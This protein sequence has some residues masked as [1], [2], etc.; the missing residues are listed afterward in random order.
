MW[1]FKKDY[2]DYQNWKALKP[3]DG[4]LLVVEVWLVE[5]SND[6]GSLTLVATNH[7]CFSQQWFRKTKSLHDRSFSLWIGKENMVLAKVVG[8]LHLWFDEYRIVFMYQSLKGNLVVIAYLL[9]GGFTMTFNKRNAIHKNNNIFHYEW[10][11]YNLYFKLKMYS[12][13]NT[14]FENEGFRTSRSNEAYLWHLRLEHFNQEWITRAVKDK[15]LSSLNE[16]N[17][18]PSEYCLEGKMIKGSYNAKGK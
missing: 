3:Q 1:N 6:F 5:D 14:E 2:Q 13:L 7:S 17:L 12:L 18:S 10:M 4:E 9:N 15:L 11:K 16:V 8:E